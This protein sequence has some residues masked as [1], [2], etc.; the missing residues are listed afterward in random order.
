[1]ENKNWTSVGNIEEY[2]DVSYQD[3][4][5]WIGENETDIQSLAK[6]ALDYRYTHGGKIYRQA[7]EMVWAYFRKTGYR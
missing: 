6:N 4:W 3:G 5:L 7:C 1:M 2:G